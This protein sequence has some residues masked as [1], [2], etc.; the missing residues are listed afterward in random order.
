MIKIR[1][2]LFDVVVADFFG[3]SRPDLYLYSL[4]ELAKE[5]GYHVSTLGRKKIVNALVED[6]DKLGF[7]CR[8]VELSKVMYF[9]V[10][11]IPSARD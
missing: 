5:T 11:R 3:K 7:G 4:S 9:S 1:R 10:W 2:A 6:L 8:K